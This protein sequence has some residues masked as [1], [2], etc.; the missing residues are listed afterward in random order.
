MQR[1]IFTVSW[2]GFRIPYKTH[3][4]ECACESV[5]TEAELVKNNSPSMW[6]SQFWGWEPWLTKKGESSACIKQHCSLLLPKE[7]A[8]SCLVPLP[9]R[10]QALSARMGC[11]SSNR[12]QN[13]PLCLNCLCWEFCYSVVI[14]LHQKLKQTCLPF[15]QAKTYWITMHPQAALVSLTIIC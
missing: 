14:A 3:R 2:N 13:N 6:E 9:L 1:W 4:Q 12:E 7:E 11:I 15:F 10:C 8:T 5:S